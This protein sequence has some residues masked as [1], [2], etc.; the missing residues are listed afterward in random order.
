MASDLVERATREL[1]DA[2]RQ[3][4]ADL[5]LQRR[6]VF[7]VHDATGAWLIDAMEGDHELVELGPEAV[8]ATS[9]SALDQWIAARHTLSYLGDI[10]FLP[11]D[12]PTLDL[13]F[14]PDDASSAA[15][16]TIEAATRSMF[17]PRPPRLS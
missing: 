13:R 11:A 3:A 1:G 10:A 12:A 4:L 15:Q 7:V 16:G 9:A 14:A 6:R 2:E 8:W 17:A 5:G